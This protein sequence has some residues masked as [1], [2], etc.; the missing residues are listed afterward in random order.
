MK[1]EKKEIRCLKIVTCKDRYD[2]II[3]TLEDARMIF[4][5]K[6]QQEIDRN[7]A[8]EIICQLY[9]EIKQNGQL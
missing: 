3:D 4:G 1:K 8:L 7:T 6:Y 9:R 2:F 5:K